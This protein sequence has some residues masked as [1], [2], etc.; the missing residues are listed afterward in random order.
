MK[1]TY[2]P[3]KISNEIKIFNGLGKNA[4]YVLISNILFEIAAPMIYV[5]SN[6]YFWYKTN[7]IKLIIFF[8]IFFYLFLP[9]SFYLN[10]FFVKKIRIKYLLFFGL[11]SQGVSLFLYIFS[12]QPNYLNTLIFGSILGFFNGFY[13]SNRN[14][15]VLETT[16]D[17]NRDYYNGLFLAAATIIGIIFN[18]LYGNFIG[19]NEISETAKQTNYLLASFF[20]IGILVFSGLFVLK[21]RYKNPVVKEIY[22]KNPNK[23]WQNFRKIYFYTGVRESVSFM[24]PMTIILYVLNG[25]DLLGEAN[26]LALIATAFIVYVL[27][28]FISRKDRKYVIL[29]GVFILIINSLLLILFYSEFYSF[30]FNTLD[31]IGNTLLY[32]SLVP[33]LQKELDKQ[34]QNDTS[35]YK[36]IFDSDLFINFGRILGTVSIFI[37]IL[38]FGDETGL[39]FGPLFLTLA[40]LL[41]LQ[42]VFEVKD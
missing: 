29:L 25:E 17:K 41:F 10:G 7:D 22:L 37:I 28:R 14:F 19:H 27:G 6:S 24:I 33:L 18:S 8:N 20:T 1:L 32:L 15:I 12:A 3:Q 16:T 42:K 30:V 40:N 23:S 11:I 21:G 4:I 2:L 26:S 31:A 13:W 39:K 34:I 9:I 35:E 5:F 38:A 36:Y